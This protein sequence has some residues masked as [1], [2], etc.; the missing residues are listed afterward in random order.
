[1]NMFKDL[2]IFASNNRDTKPYNSN[3]VSLRL[4]VKTGHEQGM[5]EDR[6]RKK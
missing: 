5:E 6:E 4:V 1:M 2:H 3:R